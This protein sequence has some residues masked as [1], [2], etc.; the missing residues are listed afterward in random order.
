MNLTFINKNE[1]NEQKVIR[2]IKEW[3]NEN[4]FFES[5]TSGST[6]KPKVIQIEKKYA[7]ASAKA[8]LNFLQ[9]K[10][11]ENALL[12]LDIDT[13]GGKMMVVRSLIQDLNLYITQPESNPLKNCPYPIDFIALAPIQLGTILN[14]TPEKLQTI[15]TIIVG[16]GI[17][18]ESI[19]R[20]LKE[21]KTTVYQ[22]FGM[23]ETISHIALRKVGYNGEEFYTAL[24]HVTISEH[25]NQLVLS[26]PNIGINQLI[27]ND[28]ILLKSANQ[29]QWI[30]R[31]DNTINS[32]GI[33]IQIE[34]L[35]DELRKF[36]TEQFFIHSIKDEILGEKIGLIIEGS[37]YPNY[38]QKTFYDFL[39]NKYHVPK[40]I[41]YLPKFILTPSHKIH[42]IANFEALNEFSF[43]KIL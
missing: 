39:K 8:T 37:H 18:L 7:I 21:S 25:E 41:A 19:E 12:C 33:K 43:T 1:K 3:E 27:T 31:N 10:P 28:I 16:G 17:I 13:I 30:G 38:H 14:E 34:K 23:T 26:A 42:R 4:T 9:I 32:G 20:R 11:T 5:K 15:R 35:E 6:G 29:F 24:D 2:F 36:I 40:V 22:T